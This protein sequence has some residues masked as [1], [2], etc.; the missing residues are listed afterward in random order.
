MKPNFTITLANLGELNEG[1]DVS[2]ELE[3]P[4]TNDEI[5]LAYNMATNDGMN[6]YII[7]HHEA[8]FEIGVFEKIETLGTIST[9]NPDE[10]K[11]FLTFCNTGESIENA[12]DYVEHYDFHVYDFV[13]DMGDVAYRFVEATGM[14]DDV[15]EAV[16]R[17]FDHDSYGEE[18]LSCGD[19][20][21]DKENRR[22]VELG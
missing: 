7:T 4:A 1:K 17:H 14:L 10:Y 20:Y 12:I 15:P 18:L 22:I 5:I 6:D 2:I 19:F 11:A 9:F 21:Q 13:D 3:F 8:D 16:K